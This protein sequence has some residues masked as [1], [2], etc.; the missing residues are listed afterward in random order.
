ML[1]N[2]KIAN[3]TKLAIYEEGEGRKGIS[4]IKYYPGD[5][6]SMQVIKG[7]VYGT[8]AFA[9][10]F[11]LYLTQDIENIMGILF[12]DD[13]FNYILK[14]VATY[15]GFIIIYCTICYMIVEY[16]YMKVKKGVRDYFNIMKIVY[17]YYKGQGK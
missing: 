11:L 3:M 2:D 16:K 4:I 17:S 14:C 10:M 15:L 9:L 7:F 12:S 1:N 13:L 8:V 5:Y 6:K